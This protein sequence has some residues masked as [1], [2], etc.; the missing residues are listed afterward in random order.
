MW[1]KLT[2][3][4]RY[5]VSDN[6]AVKGARGRVLKQHP[7]MGYLAVSIAGKTRKVHHLVAEAFIGPR[8]EGKVVSH[9]DG[10]VTNNGVEN[11]SYVTPSE[12]EQHKVTHGTSAHGERN[13]RAKLSDAEVAWIRLYIDAGVK[14]TSVAE[15]FG[16]TQ[17]HVS[18]IKR[19]ATR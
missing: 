5:W 10:D 2:E 1:K 13:G 9:L 7:V 17:G 15:W 16:I 4:E 18:A 19:G 3:D 8:P 14:Q 11:L 12:N 6:G